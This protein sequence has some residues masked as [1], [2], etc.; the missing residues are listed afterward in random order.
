[1]LFGFS[2]MK[3][4]CF[5]PS[6]QQIFV[7][8]YTSVC[9]NICMINRN[10]AMMWNGCW[11]CYLSFLTLKV[12]EI[13]VSHCG[14]WTTASTSAP[15]RAHCVEIFVLQVAALVVRSLIAITFLLSLLSLDTL[16]LFPLIL[17]FQIVRPRVQR[18]SMVPEIL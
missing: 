12:F 17:L 13:V 7:V 5:V 1:M 10:L 15:V 4:L 11:E 18:W 6:F 2:S 8:K 9:S 3:I 14:Y 16:L